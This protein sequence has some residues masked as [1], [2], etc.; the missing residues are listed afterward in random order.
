MIYAVAH[1]RGGGELGR[2]WLAAQFLSELVLGTGS[3]QAF[4]LG[5]TV[6]WAVGSDDLGEKRADT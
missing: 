6:P 5:K 2:D 3:C 4:Y 1:V